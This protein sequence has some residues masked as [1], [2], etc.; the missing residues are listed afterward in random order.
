MAYIYPQINNSTNAGEKKLYDVFK[1]MLPSGFICYHNRKIELLEFDFAVLI[2]GNGILIIESKGYKPDDIIGVNNDYIQLIEGDKI[3]SPLKQADKYR[4]LFSA[5]IKSEMKKNIPIFSMVAYPFIDEPSY[6]SKQLNV[7]SSREHTILAG[8]LDYPLA[9]KMIEFINKGKKQTGKR[10]SELTFS[11]ISR[12]RGFFEPQENINRNIVNVENKS[13]SGNRTCYSQL[14]TLPSNLST[15]DK[16]AL[17]EKWVSRWSMGTK[18]III[19]N[20]KCDLDIVKKSFDGYITKLDITTYD[21]FTL[22]P[23]DNSERLSSFNLQLYMTNQELLSIECIDGSISEDDLAE[24][25]KIDA[26]TGFNL[27]QYQLEHA[28][29][30]LDIMVTAGAGTGKTTSM[31]SRVNYLVY[32]HKL[33]AQNLPDTIFMITFTNDAA[34]NMKTKLK[35]SFQDYFMLTMDYEALLLSECIE[36]MKINTIHSLSKNILEHYSVKLGLGKDLKISSGKYDGDIILKEEINSFIES[37]KYDS[38]ENGMPFYELHN[39]INDVSQKLRSK[40]IDVNSDSLDWGK[41]YND[42]EFHRLLSSVIKS[43][44]KRI[45]GFFNEKSSIRLSDLMIKLKEL[46]K[47]HQTTLFQEGFPIKYLFVDEFQ[48]TDDIQIELIKQFKDIFGFDLFVV[49]DVKQCIY[50]FRGATDKAFDFLAP[51]KSHWLQYGLTKNYRSDKHLLRTF[52]ERFSMWGANKLLEYNAVDQLIGVKELNSDAAIESYY[53]Q[54]QYSSEADHKAKFVSVL[55]RLQEDISSYPDEKIAVLVRENWQVENIKD[56]CDEH[57]IN[58]KTEV[59]GNLY[60]LQPIIDLYKLVKALQ[61]YKDVKYLY[62]LYSTY[63]VS[64]PMPKE[65]IVTSNSHE[66]LLG[67][68]NNVLNP[69][70]NWKKYTDALKFEPVLKVLREIVLDTKPWCN[71]AQHGITDVGIEDSERF[72]KYNLDVIFEKLAYEFNSDYLTINK[73]DSFLQ[74]MILTNQKAQSRDLNVSES[75]SNIV[76]STI[77]KAKGLEYYAVVLPYMASSIGSLNHKGMTDIIVVGNKIGYSIKNSDFV[78]ITNDYYQDFKALEADNRKAEEARILYVAMTRAKRRF[79]FFDDFK[80][81]GTLAAPK[82]W[83]AL[84]R[85]V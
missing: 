6:F 42:E 50:R 18:T 68:F 26:E 64:N 76:C 59:G 10:F 17:I 1:G 19:S 81:S 44:E 54:K 83:Q 41:S 16:I 31:V 70:P 75:K 38:S 11:L 12:I 25:M 29:I 23:C 60:R 55:K 36:N 61:H 69:I 20:D 85:R 46:V 8:D 24:L 32:K 49:G 30:E 53:Y 2:P 82:N 77:H 51:D 28:P 9:N 5:L 63:Y 35:E 15:Q 45:R 40:N 33:N 73:I 21:K 74:I 7:L 37:S 84:L 67:L 65:L 39:R 52:D 58:V 80:N 79:I 3:Y 27:K 47:T 48:D 71:Y 4:Y 34:I 14:C 57:G 22:Y 62:N 72:Y 13:A 78:P 56:I 43:S 66:V